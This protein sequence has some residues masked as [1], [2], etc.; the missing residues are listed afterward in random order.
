[1]VITGGVQ[2]VNVPQLVQEGTTTIVVNDIG[3]GSPHA[4]G[5]GPGHGI[6]VVDVSQTGNTDPD[7]FV[8]AGGPIGKGPVTYDLVL[9]S[10]SIWYLQSTFL[11]QVF[12][13]AAAPSAVLSMARDYMGNLHER[14]GSREQTWTGGATQISDGSG[15]WMR[16][17][18]TF[19]S[20]DANGE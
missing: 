11:D 10:D 13:Y 20:V 17:G 9:E 2:D 6:P 14:V 16:A 7:D 8:L 18:G 3:S 1:L 4:S 5:T 15:V 12:G 19:S